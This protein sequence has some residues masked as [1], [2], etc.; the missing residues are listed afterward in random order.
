M[1]GTIALLILAATPAWCIVD[2]APVE[3]GGKPG[4]SG[5][6]AG[7]YSSKSGNTDKKDYELSGRILHDSDQDALAFL[8]GSYERATAD[9]V[10]TDDESFAHARY[11]H[12]LRGDH[13]Y[14]E[15]FVQY[16]EDFFKGI[17]SRWL[18]GGDLRWR[19]FQSDSRGSLFLTVGAFQEETN[20]TDYVS[21]EDESTQ[22]F[23]GNL[24]Y[25]HHLTD[26]VDLNLVGYAQPVIDDWDDCYTSFLAELKVEVIGNL[27]LIVSY[28]IEYDSD[29]PEGVEKEDTTTK[30]ALSWTF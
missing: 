24:I 3:V 30:T 21:D 18:L 4:F 16:K 13:L 14:G 25:T 17:D 8:Q 12:R 19:L 6:V 27:S 10:T 1:R 28:E 15:L 22:R 2:I 29:P 9:D 26:R 23:N 5:H 7:A 11:L 20:Y